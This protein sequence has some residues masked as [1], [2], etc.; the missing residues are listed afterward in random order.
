MIILS[1]CST[2]VRDQRPIPLPPPV[3]LGDYTHTLLP[4]ICRAIFPLSMVSTKPVGSG[5]FSANW[6]LTSTPEKF[7]YS[8]SGP[9]HSARGAIGA[10]NAVRLCCQKY[11]KRVLST[12]YN[13]IIMSC[14]IMDGSKWCCCYQHSWN[15]IKR[16][17]G[18][19]HFHPS[20]CITWECKHLY[21]CS[22][23]LY[24]C[25]LLGW[26]ENHYWLIFYSNFWLPL[27]PATHFFLF[28]ALNMLEFTIKSSC[29]IDL[30]KGIQNDQ[31][32]SSFQ[33]MLFTIFFA[34]WMAIQ[35]IKYSTQKHQQTIKYYYYV[36][37]ETSIKLVD[38][39]YKCSLS[40]HWRN[41]NYFWGRDW[42]RIHAI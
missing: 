13:G 19:P 23:N 6:P 25:S 14:Y 22:T 10:A 24:F 36:K 12:T 3:G 35:K 15:Y 21:Y 34:R 16:C 30:R 7:K 20:N 39:I 18:R 37:S 8:I 33:A 1:E 40:H 9:N 31:L 29:T 11:F 42:H 27:F 38:V 26:S 2:L 4:S 28:S 32:E 17:S 5:N 41:L